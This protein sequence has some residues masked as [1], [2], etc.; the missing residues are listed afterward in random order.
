M[1][2]QNIICSKTR[3][4]GT[5]HEQT[6]ICGQLFAG[7]VVSSRPMERKKKMH[8]MII[9]IIGVLTCYN[10]DFSTSLRVVKIS[11]QLAHFTGYSDYHA[12]YSEC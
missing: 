4:D 8:R 2:E 1:H 3:L 6:I 7:H 11:Q 10:A 5:T 9:I 12:G